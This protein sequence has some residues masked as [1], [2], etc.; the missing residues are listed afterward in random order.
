MESQNMNISIRINKALFILL[1][2]IITIGAFSRISQAGLCKGVSDLGN[3]HFKIDSKVIGTELKDNQTFD[4]TVGGKKADT[5]NTLYAKHLTVLDDGEGCI[6][7]FWFPFAG[8]IW[9]ECNGPW[10]KWRI[11]VAPN[12]TKLGS[13]QDGD[14]QFEPA[15]DSL[16]I[17][18]FT[19]LN[20]PFLS[21]SGSCEWWEVNDGDN[22][23]G[24][25]YGH[26]SNNPIWDWDSFCFNQGC[27]NS[28]EILV[29]ESD[30]CWGPFC[31]GDDVRVY[32]TIDKSVQL[33]S[34]ENDKLKFILEV[35]F[36]IDPNKIDTDGDGITD[37]LEI[38]VYKTDPKK[39]DTDGDGL[40]DALE[41][42]T[43]KTNPN[44]ADTDGDGLSDGLEVNTYNSDPNNP[45]VDTDGDGLTDAN[46]IVLYKTD[47]KKSDTDGD[48]L[49]D[50]D[51]LAKYKTSPTKSDTDGDLL[52]DGWE[53]KNGT[54]PQCPT[55]TLSN[56]SYKNKMVFPNFCP[57]WGPFQ[58]D[59]GKPMDLDG[60]GRAELIS[61]S[62]DRKWYV[63]LSSSG[64]TQFKN[65]P[66]GKPK[67]NFGWWDLTFDLSKDTSIAED[68]MLFPNVIDYNNDGKVDLTLY[69]AV[70]GKWYVSF[71]NKNTLNTNATDINGILPFPGWDMIVDYSKQPHWKPFSRPIPG[72]LNGQDFD[73]TTFDHYMDFALQT[74]DGWLL[75]DHGGKDKTYFGTFDKSIQYLSDIQLAE[76]PAWAWL[77]AI[78]TGSADWKEGTAIV[79]KSPDSLSDPK[80]SNQLLLLGQ[81]EQ[82]LLS[83]NGNYS[84]YDNSVFLAQGRFQT[85]LGID[86][87]IKQ[88]IQN[89]A[90]WPVALYESKWEDLVYIDPFGDFGDVNCL[91]IPADY[92]GDGYEDRAV[93]CSNKWKIAYTGSL[94]PINLNQVITIL[95]DGKQTKI[96]ESFRV[97]EEPA[98]ES[99]LPG[100]VYPG[101]VTFKET[102]AMFETAYYLCS[103]TY[104]NGNTPPCSL[105]TMKPA[106]I[107][108]YFPQCVDKV[109]KSYTTDPCNN[110]NLKVY[111]EEMHIKEASCAYE[112]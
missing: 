1:I 66:K 71:T 64:P 73:P 92:D 46:E 81:G 67:D 15:I 107:S 80:K 79:F 83:L 38:N 60:D 98:T 12:G 74:P 45:Y 86:L 29:Y 96:S 21:D 28:L 108:P 30:D 19:Q 110:P 6:C 10:A 13:M 43:Y 88:H 59:I 58:P 75:I 37:V 63:D 89:H 57:T 87:G 104:P 11:A 112:Y 84:S 72:D 22:P 99:P 27:Y 82:T 3:N 44:K 52:P 23:I 26:Y 50:G 18:N 36:K 41:I 77:P 101:G 2:P 62:K 94:Y 76:A 24:I 56:K 97:I 93:Q 85:K 35:P 39:A 54:N 31:L 95:I 69:D 16:P 106:P 61:F 55:P 33:G 90:L 9:E 17:K 100:Y 4:P 68:A 105:L 91:P 78:Y 8:C 49:S 42:N 20:G 70:H 103:M 25:Q 48:G 14:G 109:K 102:K 7:L 51:E 111:C 34:V 53:I 47:P 32:F 40:N 5:I 65:L